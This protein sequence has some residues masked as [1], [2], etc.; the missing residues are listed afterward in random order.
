MDKAKRKQ[1]IFYPGD[2][3]NGA[4]IKE[5]MRGK[6]ILTYQGKDEVL[7]MT[8]AGKYKPRQNLVPAP[9]PGAEQVGGDSGEMPQD[10]PM[11]SRRLIRNM[12]PNDGEEPPV[13][14]EPPEMEEPPIIE[15]PS[16]IEE[17]PEMEEPPIIEEPADTD[18][19]PGNRPDGEAGSTPEGPAAGDNPQSQSYPPVQEGSNNNQEQTGN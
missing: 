3:V 18:G 13:I 14:E 12:Q 11:P 5:I 16:A 4:Q 15:E 10:Q 1:D 7:D 17:P 9:F 6:V 8:E 2:V 19:E